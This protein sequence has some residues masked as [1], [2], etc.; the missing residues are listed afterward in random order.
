MQE[1]TGSA[2]ISVAPS[3]KNLRLLFIVVNFPFL[4]KTIEFR[5]QKPMELISLNIV[6]LYLC[7]QEAPVI[8]DLSKLVNFS[9]NEDLL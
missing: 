6:F 9:K 2:V 8:F 3:D 7:V 1:K 4:Y 5:I